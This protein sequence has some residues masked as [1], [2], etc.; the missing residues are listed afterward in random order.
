M[1]QKKFR[2][3]LIKFH[4]VMGLVD[5]EVKPGAL[6]LIDGKNGLG[7]TSH[8]EGIKA[9]LGKGHK[10]TLVR[11]G[12]EQGDCVIVLDDGD[13]TPL[14]V[15]A[16]FRKDETKRQIGYEGQ[17]PMSRTAEV[18]AGLRNEFTLFPTSFLTKDKDQRMDLFLSAIPLKVTK[19]QV[20]EMLKLC[21]NGKLIDIDRHAF[22]VITEIEKSIY[23]ER[24]RLNAVVT[25]NRKTAA[26]M[27]AALPPEAKEGETAAAALVEIRAGIETLDGAFQKAQTE[28]AANRDRTIA[29]AQKDFD[30][31][32]AKAREKKDLAVAES[33][34]D[35]D[36]ARGDLV[37]KHEAERT[38][39]MQRAA[40]ESAKAE[41]FVRSAESRKLIATLTA[42][43]DQTQ[44]IADAMTVALDEKLR[45]V[46]T[47]LVDQ[48]PIKGV[49]IKERDI[50]V[51]NAEGQEI[52]FDAVN[53][54]E[55]I[56]VATD[57]CLLHAG[58]LPL[59]LMDGAEALDQES[60]DELRDAMEA[61]GAQCIATRVTDDETI[62]IHRH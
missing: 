55:R 53:T 61:R 12:K 10:A 17:S 46:R 62:K 50:Y 1:A 57:L 31:A 16:T 5:A 2:V 58:P 40:T 35:Y 4:N 42:E 29:A 48:C 37:K 38:V 49:T 13:G 8:I 36:D 21:P 34:Q 33:R 11:E 19:D 3:S 24:T 28:M 43:A 20:A 7:K 56:R 26:T 51:K 39:M 25:N 54:R 22:K 18:I 23:D 9:T 15:S 47:G 44:L 45:D 27:T 41:T 59:V 52:P 14:N 60:L 30:D 6:T 32:V